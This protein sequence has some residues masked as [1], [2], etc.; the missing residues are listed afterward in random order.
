MV[1]L[2]VILGEPNNFSSA[3]A[4]V[5]L[6]L[7]KICLFLLSLLKLERR[8]VYLHVTGLNSLSVLD[9]LRIEK[10]AHHMY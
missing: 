10:S 9:S 6:N 7:F 4:V 8:K 3:G 1:D 5:T 2:L